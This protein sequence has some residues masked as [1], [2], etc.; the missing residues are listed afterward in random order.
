[1]KQTLVLAELAKRGVTLAMAGDELICRAPA[2]AMTPEI[3]AAARTLKPNMLDLLRRQQEIAGKESVHK[4][5]PSDDVPLSFNQQR[6]W[7][8]EQLNPGQ[9]GYVMVRAFRLRGTVS[10]AT[11]ERAI[12]HVV[13]R[14]AILATRIRVENEVPLQIVEPDPPITVETVANGASEAEWE[15][16]IQR[17]A[18]E[19]GR[20]PFDIAEDPLV[21][22]Y[23][24]SRTATDH[25]LLLTMHHIASDDW[26]WSIF[27]DELA[28]SYTAFSNESEPSLPEVPISYADYAA[29]QRAGLRLPKVQ[30][31]VAYWKRKLGGVLPTLDFPLDNPRPQLQTDHGARARF[32][33]PS[34]QREA[35]Q[36]LAV[37][38]GATLFMALLAVF[39]ML[40]HRYTGQEDIIV[41]T[42][43]AN[44]NLPETARLIGFFANTL[45]IRSNV[46]GEQ[47][48]L[49][50]LRSVRASCLEAY[51]HQDAPFEHVVEVV[52]P[53]RDLSR[54]PIFDVQFALRNVPRER[55]AIPGVTVEEIDV[56]PKTSKFDLFLFLRDEGDELSLVMEYNTDLFSANY[57][58]RIASSY[59]RLI[60]NVV[61]YATVSIGEIPML[62]QDDRRTQ[63]VAWNDT[64]RTYALDIT[65]H[66]MVE[67]QAAQ[68]PGAIAIQVGDRRLTYAALEAKAESI[69]AKL[70]GMGVGTGDLVGVYMDRSEHMVAALLGV[71]KAGAAYVPLD[72]Y[73]PRD[74]IAFIVQDARIRALVTDQTH[75]LEAEALHSQVV[76]C[77]DGAAPMSAAG[78]SRASPHDL[79]YVIYTS[80][81]TGKPKGVAVTH[82]NVVNFLHSMAESP[83]IA[84]R[85]T[86]LATTTLS[87]DISVLEI[88]L[89][90]T[91][92]AKVYVATR[93]DSMDPA[94]LAR[95][96]ADQDVTIMQA[97]PA[98]WE[99]LV[100][101]GWQGSPKLK[102]LCGGEA[103]PR[104]LARDLLGLVREVWNMYGPTETTVWS[105]TAKV[106]PS[107]RPVPIGS[108]IA[109]TTLYV[110]D[111][112]L[113]PAPIG[114]VGELHIGGA[115]VSKGYLNRPELTDERFVRDPFAT[116]VSARLYKTGDLARYR[117]DGMLECLGRVDNQVKI[118]G[119]RIELGEIETALQTHEQVAQ[120][121]VTA[122]RSAR[123]D[124]FDSLVA[125]YILNNPRALTHSALR[126]HLRMSLPEYMIPQFYN[127]LE[128]FPLTPNHKV[129]RLALAQ[130]R[131]PSFTA[132]VIAPETESERYLASVWREILGGGQIARYDLFFEIGGHSLLAAQMVARVENEKH[133]RIPLRAV[134]LS[135]LS[136]I[137]TSYLDA[138]AK[139]TKRPGIMKRL[140]DQIR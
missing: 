22:A 126:A 35:L 61:S 17:W 16:E 10:A 111:K 45:V 76:T 120:A 1:M 26:S 32:A 6:L 100:A 18:A 134:V 97:T 20:T 125:H 127:E 98:T 92:G 117:E 88:F 14:H 8:L 89:P 25:V 82:R 131:P 57:I 15:G 2:G 81:S 69:A 3:L 56:D 36:A 67:R 104:K 108:P 101:S 58:E 59:K 136:E 105:S 91:R 27:L 72:P 5:A 38:E 137:A 53:P 49:D 7:F 13:S 48:F 122:A 50:L 133:I 64:A 39:K 41:G 62:G 46:T 54:P 110:L 99:M 9:C 80:G 107:E 66:G 135:N 4:L 30:R 28:L 95:I 70:V 40:L 31:Q 121:I 85:D 109:N 113:E 78:P 63:L 128:H 12:R 75:N 83:G 86:L 103:F 94:A 114:A 52:N 73:Y 90:L 42:P 29:H 116:D 77:G 115:G 23:L 139:D 124:G 112:R 129:D 140:L 24:L 68:T 71:L 96:I 79:A 74:R 21:R 130:Y 37:R 123:K 33:I 102:V 47:T 51:E 87:F 34:K 93:D 118:R 119:F 55:I 19:V 132:A 84:A 106:T 60:E 11:I 43:I 138:A 44:R 65:L